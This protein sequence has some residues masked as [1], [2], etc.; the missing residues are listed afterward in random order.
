MLNHYCINVFLAMH[1]I[2]FVDISRLQ[3]NPIC[4]FNHVIGSV[5]AAIPSLILV[6]WFSET[7]WWTETFVGA[8]LTTLASVP[9]GLHIQKILP[10]NIN[11]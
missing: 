10:L 1:I 9:V 8:L 7:E 2:L 3:K 4:Q 6:L 11:L 5:I